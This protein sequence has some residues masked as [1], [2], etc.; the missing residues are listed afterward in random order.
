LLI[1]KTSPTPRVVTPSGGIFVAALAPVRLDG[2][3]PDPKLADGTD[4]SGAKSACFE[5]VSIDLQGARS[6]LEC[7]PATEAGGD[8]WTASP[9]LPTGRYEA[10]LRAT[11]R[12]RNQGVSDQVSFIV[13][14]P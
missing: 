10:R 11:D 12:A 14:S 5:I 2:S 3:A 7:S 8:T 6:D 4:G 13:V 9:S 1:D